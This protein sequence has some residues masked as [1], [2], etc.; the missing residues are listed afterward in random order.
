LDVAVTDRADCADSVVDYVEV[1]EAVAEPDYGRVR[2]GIVKPTDYNLS[3]VYILDWHL[4][5]RVC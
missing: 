2:S 5:R 3:K 4:R 1:L